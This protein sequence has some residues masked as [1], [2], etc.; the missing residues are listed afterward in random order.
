M[1]P[2]TPKRLTPLGPHLYSE[3][4]AHQAL[5]RQAVVELFCQRTAYKDGGLQLVGRRVDLRDYRPLG[6]GGT[7]PHGPLR[8]TPRQEVDKPPFGAKT[9]EHARWGEGGE[10]AQSSQS[11]ALQK[12]D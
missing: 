10:I 6:R 8:G 9:T 1:T 2:A 3:A 11:E 12:V 4:C 5:A 7:A